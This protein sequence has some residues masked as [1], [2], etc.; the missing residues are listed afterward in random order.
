M[1]L[2][3]KGAAEAWRE[4]RAKPGVSACSA[5]N[6]Q[7]RAVLSGFLIIRA[8]NIENGTGIMTSLS[9]IETM[10]KISFPARMQINIMCNPYR[11]DLS[12]W[13]LLHGRKFPQAISLLDTS[14]KVTCL[15]LQGQASLVRMK[16]CAICKGFA[17]APLF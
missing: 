9:I 4:W 16:I 2:S 15:I 11:Q 6:N 5:C 10:V 3:G 7:F 12:F 17:T 14:Q 1:P 8:E 13:R